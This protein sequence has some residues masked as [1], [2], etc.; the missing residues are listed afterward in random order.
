MHLNRITTRSRL[1]N[2]KLVRILLLTF[3]SLLSLYGRAGSLPKMEELLQESINVNWSKSVQSSVIINASLEDV[4]EYAS[5]S[6]KASE[7]SVY[8][9]HISPIPGIED[10]KKGSLRRCF[11]MAS[12]EGARWDEMTL[13]VVPLESRKIVT[14]NFFGFD[15]N[16]LLKGKYV[17]VRQLFRRIDDHRT[18]MTFQTQ[19]PSK[20]G[21]ISRIAFNSVR[22]ET[23]EIFE[24][25]LKNIKFAVEGKP[26]LYPWKK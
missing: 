23:R 19:L 14:F 7:W 25:N 16:R 21:F 12:E 13:E 2:M 4:W 9:D 6:T 20:S 3:C 24:Q 26:R 10:G 17:F 8:F 15:R 1:L 11:R 22:E 18:E 5:D